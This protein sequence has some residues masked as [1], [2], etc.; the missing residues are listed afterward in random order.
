MLL[1]PGSPTAPNL[2]KRTNN[3]KHNIVTMNREHQIKLFAC[4]ASVEFAKKV[5]EHLNLTLGDSETL[6]FSDGEFQP[7]YLESVRGATV[8][9]IQST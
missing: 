5:A 7:A 8:F 1:K 4:R 2:R 9:I 3:Y 6:T